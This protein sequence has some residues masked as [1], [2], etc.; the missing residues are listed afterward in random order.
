MLAPKLRRPLD[1]RKRSLKSWGGVGGRGQGHGGDKEKVLW[2]GIKLYPRGE[3]IKER[4]P[5]GEGKRR[6]VSNQMNAPS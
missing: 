6:R 3:V 4:R 1:E 5:G 2:I